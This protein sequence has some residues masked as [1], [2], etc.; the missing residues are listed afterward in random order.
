MVSYAFAQIGDIWLIVNVEDTTSTRLDKSLPE[1]LET[2]KW[3]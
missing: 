2:V 3:G 1:V